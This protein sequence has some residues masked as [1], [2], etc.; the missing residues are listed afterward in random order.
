VNED[1]ARGLPHQVVRSSTAA[2]A[3]AKAR[4]LLA[5]GRS[6]DL[7]LMQ[8]NARFLPDNITIADT[9]EPCRN[10]AA[11]SRHFADD[12]DAVLRQASARYNCGKLDCGHAY[13][14]AVEQRV[15]GTGAIKAQPMQT[16]DPPGASIFA[17]PESSRELVII[18]KK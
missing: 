17:R 1:K 11:G 5:Q 13:A 9:F 8:L 3:T 6:I 7:G 15:M 2:E 16:H 4:A 12:V 18:S 10:V 14:A